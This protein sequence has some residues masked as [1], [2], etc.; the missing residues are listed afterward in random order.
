VESE[1]RD[2]T[3]WHHDFP[4]PLDHC[5]HQV[6]E[7]GKLAQAVRAC[8]CGKGW[9]EEKG[10]V[11]MEGGDGRE[12]EKRVRCAWFHCKAKFAIHC[13]LFIHQHPQQIHEDAD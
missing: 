11:E 1:F 13:F 5:F 9:K 3:L 2:L 4:P 6:E 12:E 8:I 10:E 7:W